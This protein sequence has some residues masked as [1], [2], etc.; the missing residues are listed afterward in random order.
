[1]A[2]PAK[3]HKLMWESGLRILSVFATLIFALLL[4][5]AATYSATAQTFHVL[6]TF[7]GGLDGASP[8]SGLTPGPAGAFYGTTG[9]GGSRDMRCVRR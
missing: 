7:T 2:C 9:M 8:F 1:M 5:G 3:S 4:T 6:H